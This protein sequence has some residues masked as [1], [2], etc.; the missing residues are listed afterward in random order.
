MQQKVADKVREC[1]EMTAAE[2][3]EAIDATPDY[4]RAACARLGLKTA[5]SRVV[6]LPARIKIRKGYRCGVCH[7][8]GHLER[9]N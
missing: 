1:P 4:V 7:N 9:A 8:T 6:K 5:R 2:V 3:A